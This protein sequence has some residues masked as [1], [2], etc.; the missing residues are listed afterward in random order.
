[1]KRLK[2]AVLAIL[3]TCCPILSRGQTNA[4]VTLAWDA[5]PSPEVVGY[6][7]HYGTTNG[8]VSRVDVGDVTTATV[9]NLTVGVTYVFFVTAYDKSGVESDPS[10][11]IIYTPVLPA[12]IAVSETALDWGT[13]M[14]GT[15]VTQAFHLANLGG[16]NLVGIAQTAPPFN[17][18]G[19]GSFSIAPGAT[20]AVSVTFS[21]TMDGAV[22]NAV[23]FTTSGGNATNALYGVGLS[24]GKLAV[25]T[26]SLDFGIVAVGMIKTLPL[27]ITNRG[28]AAL[29]VSAT[30]SAPWSVTGCPNTIPG[31]GAANVTIKFAPTADGTELGVVTFNG[32]SG[33]TGS[34]KLSGTSAETPVA[35]ASA[36]VTNGDA[37]LAVVFTDQ[38]TG[39]ITNRLWQFGDGGMLVTNATSVAHTYLSPD[40][41]TVTLTVYGPVGV[42]T[43][44]L[45]IAVTAGPMPPSNLRLGNLSF[46]NRP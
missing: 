7:V 21:P 11:R 3:I 26:A 27:T 12:I 6:Y 14:V 5:S 34:V 39:G 19:A 20:S 18:G 46:Y 44:S 22:S 29:N 4:S 40:T 35:V 23:T 2:L 41:N 31:F 15:V 32:G 30:V 28:G 25:S 1:M 33:G 17:I 37:P 36:S 43:A 45:A 9:S 16:T 8:A 10:N 38:S 24:A 13:V 42:S